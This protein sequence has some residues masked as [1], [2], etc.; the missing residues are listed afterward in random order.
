MASLSAI[1]SLYFQTR[2]QNFNNVPI[3]KTYTFTSFF[4]KYQGIKRFFTLE[5]SKMLE[6]VQNGFNQLQS[7]PISSNQFQPVPTSSNQF[8]PVPTSSNQFQPVPTL[9]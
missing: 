5:H 4:Y 1:L 2:L 9:K 6:F 7:A 8:Q 3:T